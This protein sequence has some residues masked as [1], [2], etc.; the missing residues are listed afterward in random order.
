MASLPARGRGSKRTEALF[1]GQNVPSLPARGRG[2][3]L[4][5]HRSPPIFQRVASRAGARIETQAQPQ[6]RR[7]VG[8]SLP[9]RG[10]GSKRVLWH[11]RPHAV[12]SLPARGRGS[13]RCTL[14]NVLM[15]RSSLPARG[16][17]SKLGHVQCEILGIRRFP[18]GGADRNNTPMP[19]QLGATG[20]LPARGRGSKP[21]AMAATPA[22]VG[23]FPRGGA[24]RNFCQAHRWHAPL[25]A[26]RA[27]ARIETR[28]TARRPAW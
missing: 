20:S 6:A 11:N 17:G 4:L 22:R 21:T 3:K 26:S 13:K 18:R 8:A 5:G 25:V 14:R 1:A 24:D 19:Q 9:A 27:G 7:G 23:R 12:G 16:R 28:P 2:S 15:A 10:R